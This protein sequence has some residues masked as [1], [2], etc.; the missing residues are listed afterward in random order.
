MIAGMLHKGVRQVLPLCL[1]FCCLLLGLLQTGVVAQGP[2]EERT[3]EASHSP[4]DRDGTMP[5]GRQALN[6]VGE[7]DTANGDQGGDTQ[8]AEAEA[9]SWLKSIAAPIFATMRA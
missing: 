4:A 2:L 3:L 8:A 1:V 9:M 5:E 6:K 7:D